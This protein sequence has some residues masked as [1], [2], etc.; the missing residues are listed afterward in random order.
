MLF[1]EFK[2]SKKVFEKMSA[3]STPKEMFRKIE[4]FPFFF[5][6][7]LRNVCGFHK[8]LFNKL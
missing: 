3:E 2:S 1:N 5:R 6:S 4:T 8:N 7:A